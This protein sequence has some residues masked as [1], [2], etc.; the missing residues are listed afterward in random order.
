MPEQNMPNNARKIAGNFANRFLILVFWAGVCTQPAVVT[1]ETIAEFDT[2]RLVM[3]DSLTAAGDFARP[4]ICPADSTWIAYEIHTEQT[5]QLIIHNLVSGER[6]SLDPAQRVGD[7]NSSDSLSTRMNYDLAWRPIRF[8]SEC[9]AAYVSEVGGIQDIYLYNVGSGRSYCLLCPDENADVKTAQIRGA[10]VWSPDGKCLAYAAGLDGDPDIYLIRGMDRI[11]EGAAES[12]ITVSP[13]I[14]IADEGS[15]FGAAWC[16][17]VGSG[18]LAYNEQEKQD[19]KLRIKV[20]DLLTGEIS[21][22]SQIDSAADCFAP[23]WNIGG[24]RIAYYL[25]GPGDGMITRFSGPEDGEIGV[26]LASVY[27]LG[28]SL[29]LSPQ[30]GGSPAGQKILETVPDYDRLSG[31][32]WLPGG[33]YLAVNTRHESK[34]TRLQV[35]S[36]EDWIAGESEFDY[37]LRGFGGDRFGS[38]RDLNVVNR[39]VSFS[40]EKSARKYLMAGQIVPSIKLVLI[41]ENI[42]VSDSRRLWWNNYAENQ[43][44]GPGFLAKLGHF[45]W[46]PFVGPDLGINRGFVPVAG[47]VVLLALLIGDKDSS[48]PSPSP[49]DWTPPEFPDIRKAGP[50]IRLRFGI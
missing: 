28:D 7:E 1:A 24:N 46:S 41:P 47:G 44:A 49:R 32:S 45:L 9:W 18:F 15:Q 13:Q 17:V 23:T 2:T 22:L 12:E 38:M 5:I 50:G 43:P 8:K 3:V 31:P 25:T 11:M 29:V 26:G 27:F 6:R 36:V 42:E 37:W 14:L 10:P 48:S 40:Y 21:Q 19:A 30:T 4:Q 33:R 35:I 39:N 16:P 20:L 34:P